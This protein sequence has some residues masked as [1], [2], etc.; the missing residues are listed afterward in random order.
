MLSV[1]IHRIIS[2]EFDKRSHG[3]SK[4]GHGDVLSMMQE[5]TASF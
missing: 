1:C 3:Y 4:R 2:V 5:G